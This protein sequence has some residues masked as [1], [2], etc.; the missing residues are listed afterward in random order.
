[1]NTFEIW[2]KI[3]RKTRG[4]FFSVV[5]KKTNGEA[6]KLNGKLGKI[7]DLNDKDQTNTYLLVWDVQNH[8]WRKVNVNTIN[9]FKCAELTIV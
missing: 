2:D 3:F 8:G 9:S 6:R 5:F 4:R 7:V 1:M